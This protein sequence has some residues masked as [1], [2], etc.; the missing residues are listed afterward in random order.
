MR[1]N[2]VKPTLLT[3]F[4]ANHQIYTEMG[5]CNNEYEVHGYHSVS[6]RG[7]CSAF[8]KHA[9]GGA[10]LPF[11]LA[12]F[13]EYEEVA[14][15]PGEIPH[16]TAADI[17][18]ALDVFANRAIEQRI[19]FSWR[20]FLP[21]PDDDMLVELAVAGQASHVVTGNLRDVAPARRLGIQVVEPGEFLRELKS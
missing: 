7:I 18:V 12:L 17:D 13:M 15:R 16:L 5:G 20:P 2:G 21:D 6:G 14:K 9:T 3:I 11:W 1:R 8:A 4:K 10:N 19:Y